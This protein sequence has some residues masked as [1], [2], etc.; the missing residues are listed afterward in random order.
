MQECCPVALEGL[1]YK[2][3]GELG[4]LSK[5]VLHPCNLCSNSNQLSPFDHPSKGSGYGVPLYD[6]GTHDRGVLGHL[7]NQ[8]KGHV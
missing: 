5:Q 3:L 2:L 4:G 1:W 7:F 6:A 8:L